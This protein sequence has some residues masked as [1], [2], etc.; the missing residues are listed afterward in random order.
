MNFGNE[1][2]FNLKKDEINVFENM[3]S[4]KEYFCPEYI[5]YHLQSGWTLQRYKKFEFDQKIQCYCLPLEI[6]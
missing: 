1:I 5:K 6:V 4:E 2:Q 3:N